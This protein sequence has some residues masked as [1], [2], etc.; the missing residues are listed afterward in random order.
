MVLLHELLEDFLFQ[1]YVEI[2]ILFGDDQGVDTG[3]SKYLRG[4][5]FVEHINWHVCVREISRISLAVVC[6]L[7]YDYHFLESL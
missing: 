2:Q 6:I 1:L 7:E 4:A 5:T 3:K